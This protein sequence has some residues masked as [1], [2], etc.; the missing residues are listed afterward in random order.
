MPTANPAGEAVARVPVL[1]RKT[2]MRTCSSAGPLRAGA[3]AQ[4]AP[5]STRRLRP[6]PALPTSQKHRGHPGLRIISCSGT[7]LRTATVLV[8]ASLRRHL[9]RATEAMT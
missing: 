3:L 2:M 4:I 5:T 8:W 9:T 6:Y 1:G 7:S